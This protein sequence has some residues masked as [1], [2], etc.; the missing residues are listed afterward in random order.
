MAESVIIAAGSW[1]WWTPYR[2]HW[3]LWV[4][5]GMVLVAIINV[6]D[7]VVMHR[8]CRRVGWTSSTA[9][10]MRVLVV[11]GVCTMGGYSPVMAV[12]ISTTQLVHVLVCSSTSIDGT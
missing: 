7:G 8:C 11:S 3:Q 5:A 2:H 10:K 4:V 1:G 12:I 9:L 6:G